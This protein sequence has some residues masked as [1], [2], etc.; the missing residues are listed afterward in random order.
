MHR[1]A[2]LPLGKAALSAFT[3]T[4]AASSGN[5]QEP[6]PLPGI[7]EEVRVS[8]AGRVEIHVQ[9]MPLSNVLR[10]L[11]LEGRRNIVASPDVKGTVTANL[12]DVTFEQALQ[13]ILTAHNSGFRVVG[14]FIYV[15][16]NEELDE[17]E[18]SAH[19]AITRVF[20]LNYVTANDAKT[21]VTA[22]LGDQ[23]SV[24]ASP[25]PQTGLSSDRNTAGGSSDAAMDFLIVTAP[26][27]LMRTVERVLK[28]VDIRPRQVLVEATILRAELTG[29]NALGIDFTVVGGVDLE[30]FGATT[31]GLDGVQLGN[32]PRERFELF[33]AAASTGFSGD[34]PDGGLQLGILKDQVALFLRALEQIT[35]TTVLANPKVLVLNKQKGFVIV[36]R[37]DGYLTTTVTQ[38][39]AI[40]TVEFLETGTQLVFRPFV[41]DDGFVRVELHPEDSVGFVNAQGLPS[42]QTTEVTTNVMVRD[43]ETILIG[44]LFR[45]VTTATKKQIPGLGNLPGIGALFRS[46]S[47]STK[48]EEVII[49]LTIHVV[50]DHDAYAEESRQRIE[51][52]ERVRVGT[53]Q[54]LMWHGRERLSQARYRKALDALGEGDRDKALWHLNLALHLDHRFLPAIELKE[55]LIKER[56]WEEEGGVGGRSFIHQLIRRER[57]ITEP[58]FGRPKGEISNEE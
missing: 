46:N 7:R 44:G 22:V 47:D 51:D 41:S 26:P 52:L 33:N 40:Q 24:A 48:R 14:D 50:K 34:V 37:R 39:Q 1:K 53:R 54:G 55:R 43:G 28:D 11:S 21:Y 15:Y 38:T 17:M 35:D 5:P 12:Y 29:D 18:S 32:L 13:A 58:I 57:G 30:L 9:E 19:P 45:E 56:A 8:N 27:E 2:R 4:L 16:T 20:H 49:L 25:P 10:L 6:E 36:G 23:G 31:R 3:L 42:K